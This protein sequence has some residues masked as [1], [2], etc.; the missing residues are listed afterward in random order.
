M[1]VIENRVIFWTSG[2]RAYGS[3]LG[4]K[5]QLGRWSKLEPVSYANW[6][7]RCPQHSS[8]NRNLILAVHGYRVSSWRDADCRSRNC[9]VS[10]F[11]N[12]YVCFKF[13]YYI[14]QFSRK[15]NYQNFCWKR[16]KEIFIIQLRFVIHKYT[17]K[18]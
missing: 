14:P 11:L 1:S 15:N 12:L 8:M 18:N 10:H 4:W 17:G 9:V 13:V 16:K 3:N 6:C 7:P 2:M 5:Y